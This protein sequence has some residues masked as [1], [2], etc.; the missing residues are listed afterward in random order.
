M[1]RSFVTWLC[2]FAGL[3]GLFVLTVFMIN[4]LSLNV[5]AFEEDWQEMESGYITTLN[6]HNET[7][8]CLCP[9]YA[10]ESQ[11]EAALIARPTIW[12]LR[13]FRYVRDPAFPTPNRPKYLET[14]YPR[15]IYA[16]GEQEFCVTKAQGDTLFVTLTEKNGNLWLN[17]K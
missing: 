4:V 15:S 14:E 11:T 7:E 5:S 12:G 16:G 8:F 3:C 2:R 17:I 6:I 9:A 10:C 1:F 13:S